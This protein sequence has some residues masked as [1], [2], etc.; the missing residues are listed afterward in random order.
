MQFLEAAGGK[1]AKVEFIMRRGWVVGVEWE[2]E[3]RRC[4]AAGK[5][6]QCLKGEGRGRQLSDSNP[7]RERPAPAVGWGVELMNFLRP[8]MIRCYKVLGKDLL[9]VSCC[10]SLEA[11]TETRL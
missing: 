11:D 3:R 9:A 10:I 8:M 5:T 2:G 7:R 4:K 6:G 1:E